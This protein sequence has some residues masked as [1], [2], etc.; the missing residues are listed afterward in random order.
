MQD[1]MARAFSREFAPVRTKA[2]DPAL[3]IYTSGTTGLFSHAVTHSPTLARTHVCVCTCVHVICMCSAFV[4]V[5]MYVFG[6][7][8]GSGLV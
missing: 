2:D 6:W 7:M 4:Y 3:I 1:L 8:T 5:C